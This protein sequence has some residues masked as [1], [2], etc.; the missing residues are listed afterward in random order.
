[1]NTTDYPI[2]LTAEHVAEIMGVSKRIAYEVMEQPGFPL[3]RVGRL[4]KV[5][6]EAFEA[7]MK[8]PANKHN[9]S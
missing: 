3:I 7:W 4:K 2:V 6:R 1:M 8:N 5:N 9:A